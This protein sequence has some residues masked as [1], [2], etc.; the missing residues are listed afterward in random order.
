M[1]I[2]DNYAPDKSSGNA[3]TTAFS[4]NWNV[5][6]A[7]YFR[8]YWEDKTTGVQTLKTLGTHYTL[9]FTA[10]GYT[11]THTGGNTPPSTVWVVRAR[12]ITKDQS[13]PFK[14][15]SGWQ[16]S[17][18]ENALDKITAMDQEVQDQL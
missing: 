11:A 17:V 3:V 6:S 7:D 8:L 1:A 14:T 9:A 4:G 2:T 18:V 13:V 16:G 15:A 10:S 12:E 5:L